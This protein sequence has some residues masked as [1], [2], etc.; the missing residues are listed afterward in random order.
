ME[1]EGSARLTPGARIKRII[2]SKITRK[3]WGELMKDGL[4]DGGGLRVRWGS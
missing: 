4:E 2:V 3:S 1:N